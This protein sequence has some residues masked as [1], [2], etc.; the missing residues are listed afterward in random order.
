MKKRL[1]NSK[2]VYINV[3]GAMSG[4]SSGAIITLHSVDIDY[5]RSRHTVSGDSG[6][7]LVLCMPGSK[8]DTYVVGVARAESTGSLLRAKSY[9]CVQDLI[10]KLHHIL[11][12]GN[13]K[14]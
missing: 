3:V 14:E 2:K 6:A 1:D 9:V 5:V 11:L 12:P 7:F 8:Y 10:V 4:K 13:T